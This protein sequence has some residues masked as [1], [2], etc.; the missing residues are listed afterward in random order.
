MSEVVYGII[1][2]M[3]SSFIVLYYTYFKVLVN[4]NNKLDGLENF[5]DENFNT[6][7]DE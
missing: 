5:V 6:E 7:N 1:I 2:G 4:L 3:V